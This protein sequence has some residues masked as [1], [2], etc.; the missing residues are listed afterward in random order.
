MARYWEILEKRGDRMGMR[1]DGEKEKKAYECGYEDG[2][3]DAMEEM[4]SMG[5]RRG[6]MGNRMG[7]RDDDGFGERRGRTRMGRFR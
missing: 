1:D 5:E 6:R 7:E 2:Y 3:E 4:E